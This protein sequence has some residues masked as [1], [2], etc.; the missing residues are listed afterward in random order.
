MATTDPAAAQAGMDA[1]LAWGQRAGSA[2]LDMGAPV[3]P[4]AGAGDGDPVGGFTIMQA[5]SLDALQAV[6]EGHPHTEWGGTIEVLE[7][8]PMPGM[9]SAATD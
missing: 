6:L 9:D 2:I 7:F 1:W 4:V 5:D 3:Q 8:L